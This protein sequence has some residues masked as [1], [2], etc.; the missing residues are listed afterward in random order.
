MTEEER[1]RR[2]IRRAGVLAGVL[3]GLVCSSL[4]PKYQHA[5]NYVS[6]VVGL[7]CGAGGQGQ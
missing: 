3:L 6:Q 1:L 5:C 4:P 7:T 2:K